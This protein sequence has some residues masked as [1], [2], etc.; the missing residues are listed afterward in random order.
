MQLRDTFRVWVPKT[1]VLR[2]LTQKLQ[3]I[4]WLPVG[5]LEGLGAGGGSKL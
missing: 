5:F 2:N 4:Q 3:P 1:S